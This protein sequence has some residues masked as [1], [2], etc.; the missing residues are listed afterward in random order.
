M[1]CNRDRFMVLR[2]SEVCRWAILES[3]SHSRGVVR[4]VSGSIR[5]CIVQRN[6][7]NVGSR[8]IGLR[9]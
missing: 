5:L 6:G 9:P 7:R 4:L 8:S 3:L 1:R 2:L